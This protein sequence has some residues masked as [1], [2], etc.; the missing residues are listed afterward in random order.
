MS[1]K[2]HQPAL[3]KA[4]QVNTGKR[5]N[6][7]PV[8]IKAYQSTRIATKKRTITHVMTPSPNANALSNTS[9]IKYFLESQTVRTINHVTLRFQIRVNNASLGGAKDRINIAATPLWFERIEILDRSTGV[10][11][12]TMYPDP[13]WAI[14]NSGISAKNKQWGSMCSYD[15]DRYCSSFKSVEANTPTYFY[16]PLVASVFDGF[17]LDMHTI[18]GDIEF[19]LFPRGDIVNYIYNEYGFATTPT[20]VD[21]LEVAGI[22]DES[23]PDNISH[24]ANIDFLARHVHSHTYLDFQQYQLPGQTLNAGTQYEFDLDQFKHLSSMLLLKITAGGSGESNANDQ[25]IHYEGLEGGEID[26]VSVSGKSLLGGGRALKADYLKNIIIA[27]AWESEFF[28]TNNLYVIPFGD[29]H[30]SLAGVMDGYHEFV[31]DKQRL[32]I[33][34][35]PA[36]VKTVITARVY[37]GAATDGTFVIRYKNSVMQFPYNAT[38]VEIENRLRAME[39][40]RGEKLFVVVTDS[41]TTIG[42]EFTFSK[43]N[44]AGVY[45]NPNDFTVIS[46]MTEAGGNTVGVVMNNP[47]RGSAGWRNN[48]YN[49]TIYSAFFRTINQDSG[50]LTVK[51]EVE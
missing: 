43:Y 47:L 4:N 36:G 45:I 22:Y 1:A 41:F 48:V 5:I 42:P 23:Y 8:A 14:M 46:S 37:G 29:F 28:D 30:S 9:Q 16:L 24:N 44:N 35:P 15:G 50:R 7:K 10:C 34:T 11:I 51:D 12:Q 38:N 21:L 26:I 13:Q 40:I 25:S 6:N 19:R 18:R 39:D 49:V 3:V 2:T 33:H 27:G 17:H 32:Q 31:G 20:T